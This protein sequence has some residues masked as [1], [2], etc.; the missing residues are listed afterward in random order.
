MPSIIQLKTCC[1]CCSTETGTKI[2]G[3][4]QTIGSAIGMILV[5]IA[6]VVSV[7]HLNKP[8]YEVVKG[9]DGSTINDKAI[10]EAVIVASAIGFVIYLIS[11]LLGLF[12]L[13]GV[14]KRNMRYVRIWVIISVVVLI[15]SL[16][17]IVIRGILKIAGKDS[18]D[19]IWPIVSFLLSVYFTLVVYSF[20]RENKSGTSGHI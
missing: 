17:V 15:L 14:Y 1:F 20:Y 6:L 11:G 8:E 2:I 13:I 9:T 7:Q 10:T 19:I 4:L 16:A 12:L 3:W 5:I 18:A